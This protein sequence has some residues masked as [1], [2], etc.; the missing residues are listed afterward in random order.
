MV[1]LHAG[2]CFGIDGGEG[3]LQVE[4]GEV[5]VVGRRLYVPCDGS[6][7]GDRLGTYIF[8]VPYFK[9]QGTHR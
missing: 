6:A 7:Y 8:S 5:L 2:G 4:D 9:T 3:V 1:N